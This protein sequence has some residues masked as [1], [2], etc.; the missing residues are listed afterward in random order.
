MFCQNYF[1][2]PHA[3]FL[4]RFH[5]VLSRRNDETK[6]RRVCK[7]T[8]LLVINSWRSQTAQTIEVYVSQKPINI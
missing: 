1:P 3:Y 6:G 5:F 7:S 2:L 4:I 8:F